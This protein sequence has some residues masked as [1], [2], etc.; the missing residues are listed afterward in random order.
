MAEVEDERHPWQQAFREYVTLGD[1][2]RYDGMCDGAIRLD[3]THSNLEQRWHDILVWREMTVFELKEKLYKHCGSHVTF[4]DLYLRRGQGTS[5]TVYLADEDKTLGYYGCTSGMHLHMVDNNPNSISAGGWLENVDLVEKFQLTDEQYDA[6][7]N[8][9]RAYK[10]KMMAK[11]P[12]FKFGKKEHTEK[13]PEID[14]TPFVVDARCEVN[15]GGRRGTVK[16][17]GPLVEDTADEDGVVTKVMGADNIYGKD[18]ITF[19]GIQLDE[20][21]GHNDGMINGQ[22]YFECPQKYGLFTKPHNVTIGDFPELD[23]FADLESDD[24]I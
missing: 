7:E 1:A 16:F 12:T 5:N 8:T 15:P 9:V 18:P 23:P 3:I 13:A 17:V 10:K 22:R 21:T 14:L 24:E 19:V 20:P 2:T 11:D 6:R 4:V